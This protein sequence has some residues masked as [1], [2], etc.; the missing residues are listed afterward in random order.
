MYLAMGQ[1]IYTLVPAF[2][3]SLKK[4]YHQS[5]NTMCSNP[6]A[7][8]SLDLVDPERSHSWDGQLS[9]VEGKSV[10]GNVIDQQRLNEKAN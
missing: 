5:E 2:L 10:F 3:L 4:R 6:R 8:G 1:Q 9:L 7:T